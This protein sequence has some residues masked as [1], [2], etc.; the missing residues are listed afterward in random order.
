MNLVI[1]GASSGIG[2]SLA[3]RLLA[4]GH[5]VWGFSCS[6]GGGLRH[7]R[8]RAAACDVADWDQVAQLAGEIAQDTGSV[9]LDG[10]MTCAALQ[11]PVG[12]ALTL[13]PKEWSAAVRV[14][15]D[16]TFHVIRAFAHLLRPK[17]NTRGKVLCFSGGGATRPRANFSAYAAAK[18]GVV[19][20]V[21][22]LAEEWREKAVDINAIA[23]GAL[24]TAMTHEI[25]RLG[26]ELV[27]ELEYAQAQRTL[28]QGPTGF[29]TLFDLT[30]FLL[31]SASDGLTGKLLSAKWDS[32]AALERRKTELQD[33]DVFT[34]RRIT[35][36][37]RGLTW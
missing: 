30:D 15:L 9:G 7:P 31:S 12:A 14:N 8:F 24:L 2:R 18:T 35:P 22:T 4:Q 20:L 5:S 36:E 19:R 23:P 1:S 32:R 21:E 34:L 6:G 17:E 13:D 29:A 26:P 10:I 33:L 37:D 11:G 3:E 25:L 16:G 27:G 28:S